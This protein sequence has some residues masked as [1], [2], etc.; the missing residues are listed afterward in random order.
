M[1]SEMKLKTLIIIIIVFLSMFAWWA[2]PKSHHLSVSKYFVGHYRGFG[3]S[4]AEGPIFGKRY[5]LVTINFPGEGYS[6][7]KYKRPGYN[8]FKRFYPDGT[9]AEEGQCLVELYSYPPEPEPDYHNVLWSKCYKP[10]GT[11]CSEIKNGTGTQIYWTP[12]GVKVW[13]L[14]LA[15]FKRV[16]HSTWYQN[17]QLNVIQVYIDDLVDGPFVSYYP[18]GAKKTEGAYSKGDLV[19]KLTRYNEDGSISKIEDYTVPP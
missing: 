1:L 16:C 12:E 7:V 4:G 17:G 5:Y 19:G 6:K 2:W 13:E 18:S 9:L 15:D 10:D 8:D 11:M 14:E 3:I